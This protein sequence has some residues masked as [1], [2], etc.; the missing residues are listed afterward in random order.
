V[1]KG[2]LFWFFIG[3]G[4]YKNH[5]LH[6]SFIHSCLICFLMSCLLTHFMCFRSLVYS[7]GHICVLIHSCARFPPDAEAATPARALTG[8][9]LH[10][11]PAPWERFSRRGCRR[12]LLARTRRRRRRYAFF[13]VIL[14]L[15]SS[16]FF[17]DILHRIIP[18]HL[19]HSSIRI[20][21]H[22]THPLIYNSF[23]SFIF[24]PAP[25]RHLLTHPLLDRSRHRRPDVR[26]HR[27]YLVPRM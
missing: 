24:I 22:S 17:I 10:C 1:Q 20:G 25:H 15:D 5:P 23:H 21:L 26:Y 8:G 9:V 13:V 6:V 27:M 7:Y 11:A 2:L 18:I 14:G 4:A 3:V 16:S 19:D 12:W